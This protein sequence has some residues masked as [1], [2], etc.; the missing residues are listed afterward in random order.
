MISVCM[1]ICLCLICSLF[2][3]LF[4]LECFFLSKLRVSTKLV[5]IEAFFFTRNHIPPFVRHIFNSIVSAILILFN[6]PHFDL[7]IV[8]LIVDLIF[9]C[10]HETVEEKEIF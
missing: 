9:F 10:H 4:G 2:Q 3:S 7:V 5:T 6:R 1:K 8:L